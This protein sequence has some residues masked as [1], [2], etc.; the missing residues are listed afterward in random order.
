MLE[1]L[2]KIAHLGNLHIWEI[3]TLENTLGK[4]TVTWEN[5]FEKVPNILIVYNKQSSSAVECKQTL[6]SLSQTPR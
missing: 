1:Q 5:A 6:I 4:F 3:A 2:W